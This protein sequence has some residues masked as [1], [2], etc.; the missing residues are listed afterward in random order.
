MASFP[1]D[2]NFVPI[3]DASGLIISKSV[4]FAAATTGAVGVFPLFTITGPCIAKVIGYCS[5]DVTGSGTIE[6]GIAGDTAALIAQTTGSNIV[7]GKFWT[8]NTPAIDMADTTGKALALDIAYKIASN[9]L[10]AGTVTFYCY[11]RPMS[12]TSTCVAA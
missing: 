8:T 9:T 2:D 6:V 7:T 5:S 10:T 11:F 4:T 3:Q 1:R 12:P